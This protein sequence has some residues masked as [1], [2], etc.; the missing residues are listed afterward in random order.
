MVQNSKKQLKIF[1]RINDIL[2]ESA[3]F[4][5]KS[6]FY[7]NFFN[8]NGSNLESISMIA[9]TDSYSG[10]GIHWVAV[11][12][13]INRINK[14]ISQEYFDSVGSVKRKDNAYQRSYKK[15]L[16]LLS[17]YF[18]AL[19][20]TTNNNDYSINIY[21]NKYQHQE[22]NTECGVYS[23]FYVLSRINRFDKNIIF[24]EKICDKFMYKLRTLFFNECSL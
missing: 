11:F 1:S 24:S 2:D 15:I 17:V 19:Q 21:T 13:E 6:E 20:N 22:S 18:K 4:V 10:R 14:E 23:M 12:I 3:V 8:D 5:K 9:N 16:I 7:K